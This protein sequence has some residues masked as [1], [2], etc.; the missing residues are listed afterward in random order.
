MAKRNSYT[1]NPFKIAGVSPKD[2]SAAQRKRVMKEVKDFVIEEV[3]NR[4]GGGDS[5]VKGERA[6]AKLNKTYAKKQKG[7]NRTPNLELKG[8][9]LD[10]LTVKEKGDKL[11]LSVSKKENDKAE[12]HNQLGRKSSPLPKRRFIPAQKQGFNKEITSEIASIVNDEVSDG[13]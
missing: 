8:D 2:L 3:L 11:T 13:E 10:S 6:F 4:V 1:F 5:P 12:G 9:M 7:G